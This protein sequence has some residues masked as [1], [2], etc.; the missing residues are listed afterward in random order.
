M[1]RI[2]ILGLFILCVN[3]AKGQERL[4]LTLENC[5]NYALENNENIKTAKL[6]RR[7]SDTQI[8]ETLATGLPQVNGSIGI[9]RNFDVQV[10]PIPDFI[11]PSVYQILVDEALVNEEDREFGVFPAAFGTDWNGNAGINARQLI[12]DGSFFVGLE[13]AKTVKLLI[14][15]QQVQTEIEVIED[16]SKTYY[17]V[18]IAE[19][20]L[21]FLARNFEA[22]DTLLRET[23]AMYESGFAERIDVSRIKI[24]HNN[25]KADLKNT[26]ELLVSSVNLLKFQMG[27]PISQ[28]IEF[29]SGLEGVDLDEEMMIEDYDSSSYKNRPEYDVL[30]TNMLLVDLNIKNYRSRYLPNLYANFNYGYT[31]GTRTFSEL[32]ELNDQT[33]FKY[34][35]LGVALSI[36]IFDGLSKRA[37]IQRNR[38]QREQIQIA[39]DQFQN[40]VVREV[41]QS[42][43]DLQNARRNLA[44]Q[45]ENVDLANQVYIDTKIKYQEGL[46]PNLDVVQANTS[47]KEAQTNY[48]NALYDVITSQIE[49]KKA[50]G[51][52]NK[53]N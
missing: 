23:Q 22:T 7:I 38:I 5:I 47:L 26:T 29:A 20:N 27:M 14:E 51:T 52:L 9:T 15:K 16:V 37:N 21:E 44:A 17:S 34:S 3:F 49:L 19:E 33:W 35:N 12:F 32:T 31:S 8:D 40:N 24:Q 41:F 36:P 42:N 10:T 25:L 13:A 48:L 50:L 11:S 46:G 45:Q 39:I 53:T 2:F 6:E 30:N 1:N 28:P 18:L 4:K 43:T